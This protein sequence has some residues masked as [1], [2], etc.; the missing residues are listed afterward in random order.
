MLCLI[1][2]A[3]SRHAS[4][5][6]RM[7]DCFGRIIT[8]T[9]L[10]NLDT[11]TKIVQRITNGA[12]YELKITSALPISP[13]QMLIIRSKFH[14]FEIINTSTAFPHTL[15]ITDQSVS[16]FEGVTLNDYKITSPHQAA[17]ITTIT[18]RGSITDSPLSTRSQEDVQLPSDSFDISMTPT[19]TA[20]MLH[21][22]ISSHWLTKLVYVLLGLAIAVVVNCFA[23]LLAYVKQ[24]YNR[25]QNRH[26]SASMRTPDNDNR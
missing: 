23:K 20:E 3:D 21:N 5:L 17:T 4:D 25:N 11:F 18:N 24:H 14:S 2:I 1:I 16:L 15:S 8:C 9:S 12:G 7:C 6:C 10:K 13:I 26:S 22:K 19:L